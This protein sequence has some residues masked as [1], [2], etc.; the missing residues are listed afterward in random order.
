MDADASSLTIPL[1][2]PIGSPSHG[3]CFEQR[4]DANCDCRCGAGSGR[5]W[6][7]TVASLVPDHCVLIDVDPVNKN[8]KGFLK[9]LYAIITVEA[10]NAATNAEI[11]LQKH[12]FGKGMQSEPDR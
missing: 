2:I 8:A 10:T 11:G 6:C 12:H 9:I 5:C 7:P 4:H 3:L 1:V